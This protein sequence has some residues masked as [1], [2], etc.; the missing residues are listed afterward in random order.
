[1]EIG[2]KMLNWFSKIYGQLV[3][4]IFGLKELRTDESV[5]KVSKRL[6]DFVL[7]SAFEVFK[8]EE[9]RRYFD[10]SRQKQEE[11]DRLFNELGLTAFSLLLLILDEAPSRSQEKIRFW[12]Q[13]RQRV[14][15]MFQEWL[16]RI[17][18]PRQYVLLWGQ[19][20]KKRYEEYRQDQREV[21]RELERYNQEFANF[22]IEAAKSAYIRFMAVAIGAIHHL[23]RNKTNPKD[24]FFKH[25]Q[26]WLGILNSRLERE[27]LQG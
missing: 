9:F 19:L 17:G 5:D 16:K 8:D 12:Q 25:L 6:V 4:S 3:E 26:T 11:Q 13:V 22:D 15:E 24:P 10:F 1:M 18:T 20:I 7:K 27:I 21:R 23:R 14:P 2:S